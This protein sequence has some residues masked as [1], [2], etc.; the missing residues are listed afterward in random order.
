[1]WYIMSEWSDWKSLGE[2]P[3]EKK[4]RA[5]YKIRLKPE[6]VV[7]RLK[8]KGGIPRLFGL[9]KDCILTIGKAVDIKSRIIL[10]KKA[11]LRG[12]EMNHSEGRTLFLINKIQKNKIKPEDLEYIYKEVGNPDDAE[13]QEFIKYFKMYGE[14]PPLNASNPGRNDLFKKF[15]NN[16]DRL[17]HL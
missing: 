17:D 13:R 11:I 7:D 8:H 2:P 12:V 4:V 3:L 16:K 14:V 5:V 10:F 9:D 6:R 1:M 15:H